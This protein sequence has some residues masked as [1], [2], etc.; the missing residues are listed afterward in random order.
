V[1]LINLIFSKVKLHNFFSFSDVELN[2]NDMGFTLVE[3]R[4]YCKLDNA[5]SNGSGKSSLFNAICFAL[6]GETSQGISSGVENIFTDPDDC[7]VELT[8]MVD[9][10][11]YILKRYKTPK[12]DLKI[13]INGEDKSGKG[14]RESSNL[15]STYLP[16]LNSTLVNSIIILGQGLPSRFTNNKPSHRKEILENL[17]KSDFMIQ[18]IKD[19][20]EKRQEELKSSLRSREDKSLMINSQKEVYKNQLTKYRDELEEYDCFDS[21]EGGIQY[22]VK[23]LEKEI[24][25]YNKSILDNDLEYKDLSEQLEEL[26]S[27]YR[28]ILLESNGQLDIKLGP[29]KNIEEKKTQEINNLKTEIKILEK[30]IKKLDSIKDVCPT[31]GQKIP[32]INKPDTTELKNNLNKL[33]GDLDLCDQEYNRIKDEK[34]KIITDHNHLIEINLEELKSKIDSYTLRLKELSKDKI[35]LSSKISSTESKIQKLEDLKNRY[36]K[37]LTDISGVEDVIKKLN[38]ESV[39]ISGEI[40]DINAHLNIVQQMITLAKREFRGILLLNV[41]EYLNKLIKKYSLQVFNTEELNFTLNENAVDITYCNKPY[42]NLSGGEKQK[43][44]IIIQ[45][46]LRDVLS[47]QLD[48]RSNLLVCDEIFDNMDLIGCNK[49]IDLISSLSDIDSIFIISHHTQDLELTRDNS[50]VV[51]KSENGISHLKFV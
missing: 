38:E 17:T 28:S 14:I 22:Q 26:N 50:L 51:E 16:D 1:I 9:N 3:G 41:I 24:E 36:N 47:K 35:S 33:K 13:T 29:I 43:I 18:S 4:N 45:L 11:E 12:P 32:N 46:A 30:E 8:F 2:L 27:K 34:E 49:I 44:D 7:W 23:L 21:S 6:T 48:I 39:N 15:L 37:L 19:R 31:C 20:L 5:Y 25:Y 40:F 42:E 10:N